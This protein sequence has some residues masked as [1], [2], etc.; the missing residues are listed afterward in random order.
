MSAVANRFGAGAFIVAIL[1][2]TA[3][4]P[5]FRQHAERRLLPPDRG[6]IRADTGELFQNVDGSNFCE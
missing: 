2:I 6:R 3:A 1:E 5:L 4:A